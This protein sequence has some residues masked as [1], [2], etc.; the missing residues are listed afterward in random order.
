[1]ART[2]RLIHLAYKTKAKKSSKLH[3]CSSS[4]IRLPKW[5]AT[6]N[7]LLRFICEAKA[8][9]LC[10]CILRPKHV[11]SN[12]LFCRGDTEVSNTRTLV[13]GDQRW[14]NTLTYWSASRHRQN[15]RPM[16]EISKDR[17]FSKKF[18]KR[19]NQNIDQSSNI[20]SKSSN[21]RNFSR[22]KKKDLNLD[23]VFLRH[24]ICKC[25]TP[26]C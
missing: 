25:R 7:T 9:V 12:L 21:D 14:A 10:L 1:M 20:C 26:F 13:A 19:F 18:S 24:L 16:I 6:R 5:H 17:N 3:S 15:F 2:N 23:L 8:I 11:S 4:G 22:K